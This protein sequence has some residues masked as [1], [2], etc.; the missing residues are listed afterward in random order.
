MITDYNDSNIDGYFKKKVRK[1]GSYDP[2]W[3]PLASKLASIELKFKQA[4]N[5]LKK[6]RS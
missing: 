2:K 1:N 4:F 6:F 3:Y 5:N